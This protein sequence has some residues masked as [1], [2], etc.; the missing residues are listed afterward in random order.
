MKVG[1]RCCEWREEPGFR[2][3]GRDNAGD[4]GMFGKES[5]VSYPE[6]SR[7]EK[8]RLRNLLNTRQHFHPNTPSI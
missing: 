6:A 2:N 4:S 5:K 3:A 8:E 7:V 1:A